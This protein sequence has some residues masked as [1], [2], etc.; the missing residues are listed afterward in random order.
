[1]YRVSYRILYF[2]NGENFWMGR[3]SDALSYV[4]KSLGLRIF[5]FQLYKYKVSGNNNQ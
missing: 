2:N 3:F 1:M 5:E 4:C